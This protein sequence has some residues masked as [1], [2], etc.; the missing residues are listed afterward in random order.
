MT[1]EL[2]RRQLLGVGLGGAVA[3]LA[4]CGSSKS[5]SKATGQLDTGP[6]DTVTLALDYT[7][8]TN[9]TGIF[10]ADRLGYF[11]AHGVR[12]KIIPYGSATADSIL[13]AGKADLAVTFQDGLLFDVAAGLPVVSVLAVLQHN[14]IELAVRADSSITRPRDLD[15]KIYGSGGSPQEKPEI[16]AVIRKDG[17][18]GEFRTITLGAAAYDA[19]YSGKL[20]FVE[21]YITY[22][23]IYEDLKGIKVRTFPFRQYGVPDYYGVILAANTDWLGRQPDLARRFLAA[24]A[25]G[26]RYA[27][28]SPDQ[29]TAQLIAANPGVF[30][31]P[32]LELDS[33][34]LIS[35]A[36]LLDGA[37]HFGTQTLAQWTGFSQFLY[38]AGVL[39]NASGKVLSQPPDYAALFTT[40]YAPT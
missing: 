23:H 39:T 7:P 26:Y 2:S 10:V 8:N 40:D 12:L 5:G 21:Q 11:A 31:T 18:T 25:Q 29:A 33:Q 13:G 3:L 9:H 4:G 24:A 38:D 19:L 17:G 37:G 16:Q 20:D 36:Y 30:T 34:R 6:L 27:A 22:E 15:G 32:D 1:P 28:A 14:P 35:K